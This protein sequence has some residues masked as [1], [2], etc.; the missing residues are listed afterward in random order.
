MNS[1]GFEYVFPVIRG[2]QAGKEF[3]NCACPIRILCKL[4]PFDQEELPPEMRAQKAFNKV[5][6]PEIARYILENPI[7]DV[8][9]SIAIFIDA[10]V[11]FELSNYKGTSKVGWLRVPMEAR[12]KI[13]E[14]QHRLAA[15]ELAFLTKPELGDEDMSV[16]FYSDIGL[17][18]WSKLRSNPSLYG[19][20]AG[21]DP[22]YNLQYD[23]RE[24]KVILTR[25]VIAEVRVFRV[26]TDTE[27]SSLPVRSKKLFTFSAIQNATLALLANHKDEDLVDQIELAIIYWSTVFIY[28]PDWEKVLQ[29]KVSAGAI[30]REYVH[31]HAVTLAALGYL[32]ASLISL[33]PEN[34]QPILEK[35]QKVDWSRSNPEWEG[36]VLVEGRVSKSLTSVTL[37]TSYLKKYLGLPLTP[38]EERLERER[39]NLEAKPEKPL[40][41]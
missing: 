30:R 10:E 18:R 4:F 6:V 24:Y 11:T 32:G 13:Y 21:P 19:L 25:A 7:H 39:N 3:Y 16:N 34:W 9:S 12:C 14:G 35:L 22:V 31:S 23:H 5:R 1:S 36:R 2:I 20:A 38:E 8:F 15:L 40:S 37:M 41:S 26:L 17:K 28:I 33:Q 27:R 29:Q